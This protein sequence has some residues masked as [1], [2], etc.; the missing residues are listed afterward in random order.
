MLLLRACARSYEARSWPLI[1]KLVPDQA[2]PLATSAL[3]RADYWIV[4]GL[5]ALIGEHLPDNGCDDGGIGGYGDQT[6]IGC[7]PTAIDRDEGAGS[8]AGHTQ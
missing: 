2:K 3:D 4:A 6:S 5:I 1:A 7:R 8:R